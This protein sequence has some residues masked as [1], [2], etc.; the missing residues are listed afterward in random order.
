MFFRSLYALFGILVLVIVGTVLLLKPDTSSP[1]GDAS[2]TPAAASFVKQVQSKLERELGHFIE[3]PEQVHFMQVYPGFIAADFQNV[4][5][6]G[7]AFSPGVMSSADS[8]ITTRGMGTLLENIARRAQLPLATEA[9]I[10]AIIAFMERPATAIGEEFQP[11]RMKLTGTMV[12]LPHVDTTGPQTMECAFGIK[13]DDGTYYAVDFAAMSQTADPV[14]TGARFSAQGVVT[15]VERLSTD[16]WRKYPI[17]GIFSVTD[18]V[19]IE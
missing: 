5:T 6:L 8:V 19:Q 9:D 2:L 3:G 15:P 17:K 4:E 13:L 12:C 10:T 11:Q 14:P 18:S 16:H 1:R 7:D